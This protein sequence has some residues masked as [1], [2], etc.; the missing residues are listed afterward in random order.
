MIKFQHKLSLAGVMLFVAAC[1][2]SP[3]SRVPS[4]DKA[5]LAVPPVAA[6]STDTER[7]ALALLIVG[8]KPNPVKTCMTS[9]LRLH[10]GMV[11]MQVAKVPNDQIHAQLVEDAAGDLLALREKQYAAWAAG[12][13]PDRLAE[14]NFEHCLAQANVSVPSNPLMKACFRQVALP[15]Y[16]E[17]E[18]AVKHDLA[19]AVA[20]LE[21]FTLMFPRNYVKSTTEKVFASDFAK[22]DY[23]VHREVFAE[24]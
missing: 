23:Q 17:V 24:C 3:Q 9:A 7:E 19:K 22:D 6:G 16:A 12:A 4:E 1:A 2:T 14:M 15:A 20:R 10:M 5:L 18:K 21:A 8:P 11:F 13:G